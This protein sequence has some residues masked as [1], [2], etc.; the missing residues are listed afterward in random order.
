MFYFFFVLI[1]FFGCKVNDPYDENKYILIGIDSSDIKGKVSSKMYTC[2]F[3]TSRRLFVYFWDNDSIM[4]KGFNHGLK[5]DGAWKHYF[6]EGKLNSE[7]V[8]K[9]GVKIGSH[10]FYYSNGK[11]KNKKNFKDG[12]LSYTNSYDTNGVPIK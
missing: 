2:I 5:K 1:I 12:I 3:D 9:D 6:Y 4:L 8:Y 11:L 7:E 10:K